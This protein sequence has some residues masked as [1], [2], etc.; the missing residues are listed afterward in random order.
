MIMLNQIKKCKNENADIDSQEKGAAFDALVQ[1][2]ISGDND[3]LCQLCEK[4]AKGVLYLTTYLVG[5]KTDAEDIS[6]IILIRVFE[7]I[8]SLREP[9]AFNGWLV[10]IISNESNRYLKSNLK[11][12]VLLNID[13]YLDNRVEV[14]EE[15]LP[16]EYVENEE[17]RQAVIGV[18]SSLTERQKET[19]MLHYYDGLSVTEVAEVM[20]ISKQSVSEYLSVS[21]AK[22]RRELVKT[23]YLIA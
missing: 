1:K 14:N 3:A 18:L 11:F 7:N 23:G 10:R 8:K 13:D 4:I 2:A 19:V 6:Q 15:S 16:Q 9:K 20:K 12:G 21:R 17:Q 22:L 5:N